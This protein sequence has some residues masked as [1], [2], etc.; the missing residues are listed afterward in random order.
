MEED[1]DEVCHD[2]GGWRLYLSNVSSVLGVRASS[3][4]VHY[5]LEAC[6]PLLRRGACGRLEQGAASS[7]LGAVNVK[8]SGHAC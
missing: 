5:S 2:V 8:P 7:N 6:P 4:L 3:L 1:A